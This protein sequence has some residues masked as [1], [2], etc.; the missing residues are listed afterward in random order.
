MRALLATLLGLSFYAS[1][2]LGQ[3]TP[4][5]TSP[6]VADVLRLSR[7][8]VEEDIIIGF[9]HNSPGFTSLAKL[10]SFD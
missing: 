4:A 7:A 1:T 3:S 10:S 5:T 2:G 9:I 6:V 8:K